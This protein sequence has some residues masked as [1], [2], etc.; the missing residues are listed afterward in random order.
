MTKIFL[1]DESESK[2]VPALSVSENLLTVES[3]NNHVYFYSE[4]NTDRGLALIRELRNLDVRMQTDYITQDISGKRTPI[5]LHINSPGGDLFT[6]FAIADQIEQIKTPIYSI[7]E[8]LAAS[9][10]TIISRAC[11]K[12]YIL[13]NSV[14]LIH[15]FW[16]VMWGKHK[17]FK[18]EMILQDILMERLINFYVDRTHM[19]KK[20]VT[21]K[22]KHD[23]WVNPNRAIKLGLVDKI[24]GK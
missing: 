24:K 3:V 13:P 7:V 20:F 9:A 14:M 16:T 8:G 23:F 11:P 6:A 4:V 21:K 22:L 2:T 10:A 17:E 12:S 15:E 19:S 5:W 18:D 1:G